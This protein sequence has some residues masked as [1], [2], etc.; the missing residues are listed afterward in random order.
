M[1]FVWRWALSC[2]R[3]VWNAPPEL[4]CPFKKKTPSSEGIRAL[5]QST[6]V[7]KASLSSFLFLCPRT[8]PNKSE[9][10]ACC[11]LNVL[12]WDSLAQV[13]DRNAHDGA[14]QTQNH[15][16]FLGWNDGSLTHWTQHFTHLLLTTAISVYN[17]SFLI[18]ISWF[19]YR[20]VTPWAISL[21]SAGLVRRQSTIF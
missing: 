6:K 14:A 15:G 13:A 17:M 18:S 8:V 12:D 1:L 19:L 7:G 3:C 4:V 21:P 11:T 9:I 5:V 2:R 10:F 16:L 20:F